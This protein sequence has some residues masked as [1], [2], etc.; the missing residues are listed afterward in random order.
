MVR[1]LHDD[2]ATWEPAH[3]IYDPGQN[4]QTIGNQIVALGNTDL[5]NVFTEFKNDNGGGNRGGRVR[6]VA[7]GEP[8]VELDRRR[9]PSAGSAPSR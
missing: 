1:A 3:P 5:V 7:L 9:S 2:G 8:R 6:G 4:D